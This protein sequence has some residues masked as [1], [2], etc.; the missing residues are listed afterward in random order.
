MIIA[1]AG[2]SSGYG[3]AIVANLAALRARSGRKVLV[4]DTDARHPS[5]SGGGRA[6]SSELEQVLTRY[7]DI[8]IDAEGA[9]TAASRSALIAAKLAIVPVSADQ[10]DLASQYQ[11]IARLNSARM[12]NPG[13]HVCFV[14]A[15]GSADPSEQEMAAIRAYV[16]QVMSATLCGTVIHDYIIAREAGACAHEGC[17]RDAAMEMHALYREVF[18]N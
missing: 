11:L 8:I 12:F 9:D 14:I 13:L 3:K 4:I 18:V 6:L 10:V 17:E 1:I 5:G 16:A 7:N 2:Q 15:G